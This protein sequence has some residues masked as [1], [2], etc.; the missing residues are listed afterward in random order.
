MNTL[1]FLKTINPY[2]IP[3]PTLEAIALRAGV[4]DA[5][6]DIT[7]QEVNN[8][9]VR[10]ATALV[11]LALA[12]APDVSQGRISYSFTD[13]QREFFKKRAASTLSDIGDNP[14]ADGAGDQFG[15]IGED[16]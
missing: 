8:T 1:Q 10:R 3:N 7:A 14:A 15:Y 16:F 11:Y 2:P 5:K 6:G 12:D 13:S 9:P 4:E